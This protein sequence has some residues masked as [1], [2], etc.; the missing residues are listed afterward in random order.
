MNPEAPV[1]ERSQAIRELL[2]S[3]LLEEKEV[4][5]RLALMDAPGNPELLRKLAEIQRSMG[6]RSGAGQSY[7]QLTK[8]VPN[9]AH[10]ARMATLLTGQP[11]AKL[12][13]I[14]SQFRIFDEFLHKNRVKDILA[15]T[16]VKQE[17]F[18][19]TKVRSKDKGEYLDTT[20]RVSFYCSELGSIRDWF[21]ALILEAF[22]DC[23]KTLDLEPFQPGIYS[24]KLS[25][26][27]NGHF[28][29]VHQDKSTGVAA[30]RRL[31]FIYYFEFAPRRYKGGELLLYDRDPDTMLPTPSFTTLIPQH[32]SL[33]I[34]PATTWH[35]V[36]PIRIETD[37]WFAA[38]FTYS[39]W[40]H[41]E[42]LLI[43]N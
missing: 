2:D 1:N 16:R 25:A 41:D 26:Y 15:H 6:D 36:L 38:R 35:E 10:F 27:H 39:G 13:A 43:H 8:I 37:D 18:Q 19:S 34:L 14:A 5:L 9:D 3:G 17:S 23:L 42:S 21:D 7:H 22:P 33:V 40:I 4:E 28:F 32:N 20:R 30:T 29:N 11:L 24:C 12:P 31:G